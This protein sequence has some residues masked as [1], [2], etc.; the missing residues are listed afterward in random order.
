MLLIV[1]TFGTMVGVQA[2]PYE[3]TIAL[4]PTPISLVKGEETA[5]FPDWPYIDIQVK[6]TKVI[7]I[8][9]IMFS[10]EWNSSLFDYVSI[11]EGDFLGTVAT[12]TPLMVTAVEPGKLHEVTWGQL[13]PFD[14]QTYMD[15][16]WGWV[17][18]IR[19]EYIGPSP[20]P[21]PATWIDT[22]IDIVDYDATEH[23][24]TNWSKEGIMV[25][26]DNMLPCSFHYEG[27]VEPPIQSVASFDIVTVPPIYVNTVVEFDASAS[28]KGFDGDD[29]C[30]ITEW[31][32][33]FGD[34]TPMVIEYT[35]TALHNFTTL[36]DFVVTLV[37]Y[38][39]GIGWIHPDYIDT[40]EPATKPISIKEKV[41][42]GIDVYT[43]V[44][45]WPGY[46]AALVGEG[47][48]VAA[49]A[50]SPQEE[51]TLYAYVY[52][53]GDAVQNELVGFEVRGPTNP[54]WN[55]TIGRE[56]TTDSVGIATISFRITWPCEHAE[57]QIFGTWTVYASVSLFEVEYKDSLTFKV[58]WIVKLE[59]VKTVGP[60]PDY[61]DKDVF[62]KAEC[63]GVQITVTNLA[64]ADRDALVTFVVYDDVGTVIVEYYTWLPIH[65]GTEPIILYCFLDVPKF[66]YA[67]PNC[68]VYANAFIDWPQLKGTPWCPEVFHGPFDI[69]P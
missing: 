1:S 46:T 39:P 40:S 15:P 3:G 50:Y 45:R 2:E 9:G 63:I 58:G 36:G 30:P 68:M 44:E 10:L 22:T 17:V 34:G 37:V 62:K 13:A 56:A 66:A 54:Y 16:D 12:L 49:D 57:E 48:D 7:D 18:T 27:K 8:V 5:V 28:S 11:S 35:S 14:P 59:S 55:I 51:V 21:D 61:E 25:L 41:L 4:L 52:Y 32:W 43:E 67:G 29:D 20:M 38:A 31:R 64:M 42:K 6:V 60:G 24:A 69:T 33:D 65:S 53:S 26:F 23:M 19:F 47:P